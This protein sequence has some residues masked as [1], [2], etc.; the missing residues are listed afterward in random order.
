M[1][2]HY[3]STLMMETTCL[4]ETLTFN[5]IHGVISQKTELFITTGVSTSNPTFPYSIFIPFT[6]SSAF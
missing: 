6:Q 5:G 4:S 3:S 2:E 1:Y